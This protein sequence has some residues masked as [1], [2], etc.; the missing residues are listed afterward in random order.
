[1]TNS[2]DDLWTDLV[3]PASLPISITRFTSVG[4]LKIKT[5][6]F[7]LE[8]IDVILCDYH[9]ALLRPIILVYLYDLA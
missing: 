1:M 6:T 9:E 2:L 5:V 4:T 7:A 3:R 8:V